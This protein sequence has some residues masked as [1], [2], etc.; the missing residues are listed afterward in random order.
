MMSSYTDKYTETVGLLHRKKYGQFFT[1]SRVA[2]FMVNWVLGASSQT[3]FDPAF[4]L[5]A[6][7]FA[8]Q[9]VG[10]GGSFSGIEIDEKIISFFQD[11]EKHAVCEIDNADYLSV[12]GKSYSAIVCNPPYIRSQKILD[13]AEIFSNFENNLGISLSGYTNIASA[14]LVKSIGELEAG[15][16]LAY[17]MPLEFLNAGY[18]KFIKQFL[19]KQGCLK[20]VIRIDCEKD[21]FPDATTSVGIILF[22]KSKENSPTH[23]FVLSDLNELNNLL[24]TTPI[25]IAELDKLLPDEKWLKYFEEP[26]HLL[27]KSHLLPLSAYGSFSRGIATGANEFFSLNK[28]NIEKLELASTEFV[29][30]ITKSAQIRKSIF[31]DSDLIALTKANAPVYLLN[32]S[33][34]LSDGAKKYIK[35]GE[36]LDFHNR[37][38]TKFRTP[39]YKIENRTPSPLLFGVFSRDGFKVV[40]NYTDALNLTCYHGFKP[41]IFGAKYLD[42]L[43]VYFHSKVARFILSQ[44]MRR[45]GD[46]LDKFEPND[47]NNAFCP[48]MTFMEQIS[49]DVVAQE[50]AYFEEFG[51]LSDDA[52]AMFLGLLTQQTYTLETFQLVA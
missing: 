50:M 47:L 24:A 5:G 31:R 39:W 7:S 46:S 20:C 42:Y 3:L 52:E 17:I 35:H 23:F 40:R 18:G 9:A 21:V 32:L 14:F 30:C 51:T 41:N 12:W 28:G 34:N 49:V 36:Q 13:R 6:F 1:E 26:S 43:F 48:S 11:A 16:R 38:L 29:P 10:F 2:N 45:Y 15:G 22:E 8:A 44:N 4:G 33:N 27:N 19:L 37:Y 25:S